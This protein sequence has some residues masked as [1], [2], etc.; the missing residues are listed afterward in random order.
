[1]GALVWVWSVCL[2]MMLVLHHEV[3]MT[4]TEPLVALMA[5]YTPTYVSGKGP[6]CLSRGDCCQ[7]AKAALRY[8]VA[9]SIFPQKEPF[10]G[11]IYPKCERSYKYLFASE[12]C[13][14]FR[15][16]RKTILEHT[17]YSNIDECLERYPNATSNLTVDSTSSSV[18]RNMNCM[19]PFFEAHKRCI[20]E[21]ITECMTGVLPEADCLEDY[22]FFPD[23]DT[24]MDVIAA[25]PI[26][27]IISPSP[28]P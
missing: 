15:P 3:V 10:G 4:D 13:A 23:W 9:T 22:V 17:P 27:D 16:Y 6:V 18:D 5:D 12:T 21:T 14:Q 20:Y 1:M 11:A 25:Y 19:A 24:W 26:L 8:L 7:K 28:S 2:V